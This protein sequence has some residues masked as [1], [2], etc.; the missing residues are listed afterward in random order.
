MFGR[1]KKEAAS[2]GSKVDTTQYREQ[3]NLPDLRRTNVWTK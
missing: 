3:V 2:G 1:E